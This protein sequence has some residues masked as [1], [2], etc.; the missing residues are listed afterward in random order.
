QRAAEW[1]RCVQGSHYF[2][3][4]TL[5]GKYK[6]K[7]EPVFPEPVFLSSSSLPTWNQ[8]QSESARTRICRAIANLLDTNSLPIG[9]TARFHALTQYGI[10][11]GSLYRHRDLWH[12][13]HFAVENLENRELPLN[14]S[15]TNSSATNSTETFGCA[16]GAP[17]VH[18]LTSL[19]STLGG[20]VSAGEGLSDRPSVISQSTGGNRGLR[21]LPQFKPNQLAHQAND[22]S[23]SHQSRMQRFLASGDPILV[24]EALSSLARSESQPLA[25]MQVGVQQFTLVEL[26]S[27]G[28]QPDLQ[29]V[30]VISV[31]P[32]L[33]DQEAVCPNF[34]LSDTLAAISVQIRCLGW[35]RSQVRHHLLQRFGKGD[36]ALLQEEELRQWLVSLEGY[37]VGKS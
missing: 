23:A 5:K 25:G 17:N 12:P 1:A 37:L 2:R 8:Q 14:A 16:E 6:E 11:G 18:S 36:R 35:S 26:D 7:Q 28:L 4:G 21:G 31:Q 10:G 13:Q 9:A 24:A 19:L 32:L 15:A 22:D 34:D 27:T 33:G 20:N 29:P 3:Y 30:S